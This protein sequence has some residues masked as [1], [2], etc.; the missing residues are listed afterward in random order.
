VPDA[1]E[2]LIH[3]L[4]N[5]ASVIRGAALQLRE[6]RDALDRETSEQLLEM[7]HRRS[8]MLVRLV[9]D[10]S[11][12]RQVGRGDLRVTMQSVDVGLLCREAV[13]GAPADGRKVEVDVAPDVVAL[14]DPLRVTQIVDNLL[15]NALRYGGRR[16]SVSATRTGDE[17]RLSVADDGDGVAPELL[18]NL[19]E[20]Y[21]RGPRSDEHGGSGLGLAIV[22]ELCAALGGS[23]EYDGTA[24]AAFHVT[25]PAPPRLQVE[26]LA[27]P[28]SHALLVWDDDG[29]LVERLVDYTVD[30][31]S[32]G[33]AVI[34]AAQAGHLERTQ[35]QLDRLG[36]ATDRFLASGQL[37]PLDAVEL[38]RRLPVGGHVDPGRFQALAG[39]VLEQVSAR[40]RS[41][42]V[43]SEVAGLFWSEGEETLALEA[44]GLWTD[45]ARLHGVA[46][47]CAY[48]A[49]PA[50]SESR[51]SLEELHDTAVAA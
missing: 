36:I 4:R 44:E 37:V 9:G 27:P 34:V 13:T 31:L 41:V 40:W 20:V 46:S 10:L 30:G 38:Q 3:D 2:R 14:G 28:G 43:C 32:R 17:V 49:R 42:R 7:I 26:Q 51:A 48:P 25:L 6:D 47:A 15:G 29:R 8:D 5:A 11:I 1:E 18:D 24:G 33:E 39:T 19:V 21:A 22:H 16:V 50:S 23:V 12:L 35:D 45:L